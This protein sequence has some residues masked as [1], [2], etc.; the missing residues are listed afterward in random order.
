V[1]I[2]YIEIEN[3]RGIRSFSWAPAPRVNCLVGP[4]DSGKTTILDAIEL[5]LAPRYQVSFDDSDFYGSDPNNKIAITVT[6]GELPD[7]FKA[8]A[9]YGEHTRGWNATKEQIIDEPDDASG[10]EV[11]L[12]AR[13]SVDKTLEPKWM[14]YTDRSVNEEK[15]ARTFRFEDRQMMAPSRLGDYTDRH[16]AWGRQSILSRLSDKGLSGTDLLAQAGRAARK[17]FATN[18]EKLFKDVIE[19]IKKLARHVGVKLSYE[20]SARMDVRGISLNS[21]GISLHE[22]DL[23]LRLLGAGSSRLLV[24]AL[25]DF[26]GDSKPF[27]LIDEV[28]HALE[29]H[30]ISRLLRYLKSDRDG[31]PPQ[32]FLTTHSPVVLEELSVDEVTVVR[33]DLSSGSITA[34]PTKTD[35]PST[36]AQALLRRTPNA[37]LARSVLVCEGKTE[38][39]LVR[40]LDQF[41]TNKQQDP[42][43]TVGVVPTSG[44]GKDDAPKM[45]KH[46]ATLK[47][48]TALFLDSDCEPHDAAILPA[49]TGLGVE[50]IR[51]EKGKATED[52]LFGDLSDAAVKDLVEL[53]GSKE[54][55]AS[56]PEQINSLVE[57]RLLKDWDDLK[58]RCKDPTVRK[59]LAT[60]AKKHGWIKD[61][62]SLSEAIGLSV[63][64]PH[65]TDLSHTNAS[66]IE[67]LRTW[68]DAK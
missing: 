62:L 63:L 11:V 55:L 3:F 22:G 56:I 36:Y 23:P 49:L 14:I 53:L 15:E 68:I 24:A 38:V 20:I 61:R 58:V 8:F 10:L 41:W 16:L 30:R 45:A 52:V 9:A 44:G 2:R 59:H 37:F 39:G 21:G 60:C 48:R 6:L 46:F 26:A 1:K 5:A 51:W 32:L 7:R 67:L 28:E 50:V 25:Q 65:L 42:L 4:G 18:S 19:E 66:T 57:S 13:L 34:V 31:K 35:F 54:Y 33:R 29:P 12:S 43:A 27:A 64:G 47:Y 40:G 17:Q